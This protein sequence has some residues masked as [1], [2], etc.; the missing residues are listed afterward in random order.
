MAGTMTYPA[1]PAVDVS[2]ARR[3]LTA[4]RQA[5]ADAQGAA[6]AAERYAGAHLSA[7]RSAA[8]V[9]AVRTR[10]CGARRRGPT[11]AWT[12]LDVVAPELA[13]WAAVFA[14]GSRKRAA[15]EAGL[16]NCVTSR[17]ADDLLRAAH[18]LLELVEAALGIAPELPFETVSRAS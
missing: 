14:A 1:P 8:A 17:E 4:A 10:P 16:R 6:E 15:A 11:S 18:Q 12:L 9:L 7:L 3:L 5:L 13:P 2:A